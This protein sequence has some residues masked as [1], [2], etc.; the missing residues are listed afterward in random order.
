MCLEDGTTQTYRT[1]QL[2]SNSR[3]VNLVGRGTRV[4][5][6]IQVEDGQEVGEP[7]VL[8]DTWSDPERCTEGHLLEKVRA[9]DR[10]DELKASMDKLFPTMVCHGDVRL[11]DEPRILDCTPA[12]G[13]NAGNNLTLRREDICRGEEGYGPWESEYTPQRQRVHYRLVLKEVCKPLGDETSLPKIY[14]ALGDAA[15]ALRVMHIAGWVHRD[16]SAGNILLKEDG[17]ILLTDLELAKEMGTQDEH[18]VGTPGFIAVEVQSQSYLFLP[19]DIEPPSPKEKP[20]PKY[21]LYQRFF[22][23]PPQDENPVVLDLPPTRRESP[24]YQPTFWYNPLHDLESLWW[25]SLYFAVKREILNQQSPEENSVVSPP[26]RACASDFF[27][28]DVIRGSMIQGSSLLLR[29]AQGVL[30]PIPFTLVRVLEELL[31]EL[32]QKYTAAEKDVSALNRNCADGLHEIFQQIFHEIADVEVI[33]NMTVRP[34]AVLPVRNLDWFYEGCS[35]D[36]TSSCP[37]S[38]S[39]VKRTRS[40]SD[41]EESGR[42]KR[43]RSEETIVPDTAPGR[44]PYLPRRAKE[45]NV[46]R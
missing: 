24:Q 37:S 15:L 17:S 41:A 8:K 26:H 22:E 45:R 43:A 23:N 4:W 46:R 40:H 39:S 12:F 10:P 33:E 16:V 6:V 28:N 3:T 1:L 13:P 35:P 36:D 30:P 19:D 7:M 18:A 11:N 5:K 31:R 34:F 20:P 2:L 42:T 27:E 9:A 21:T 44:R 38:R 25:L 14:R 29:K 32:I